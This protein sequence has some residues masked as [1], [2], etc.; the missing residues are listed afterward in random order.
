MSKKK[1]QCVGWNHDDSTKKKISNSMKG[2][3]GVREAGGRGN[4][5]NYGDDVVNSDYELKIAELLDNEEISWNN[6][7]NIK[8]YSDNR[9]TRMISLGFYLPE[10]DIRKC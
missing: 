7:D 1:Q 2:K 9:V 8:Y 3:G 4:A 10:Y 5:Y 6:K